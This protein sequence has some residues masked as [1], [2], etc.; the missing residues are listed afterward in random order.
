MAGALVITPVIVLWAINRAGSLRRQELLGA[1]S[2]ILAASAVGLIAFSPMVEPLLGRTPLGFL[3]ILPLTWAALRRGRRETATVAL[4]VSLLAIWGTVSGGGP[5]EP[6]TQ[7][8]DSFLLL[9]MFMIST[10]VPSLVL[11]ADVELRKRT[12]EALRQAHEKMNEIIHERTV[13]L[14]HT[15]QEL[16]QAQKIDALGQ[17]TSGIAHDFNNLLTAILG[18]LEL[19]MKYVT[20]ARAVRLVT[21]AREAAQH[22]ANLTAQLLSFSRKR[23]VALKPVNVNELIRGTQ[24]MLQRMV[25]P[26]V[27]ISYDL[28]NDAWPAMAN[29]DQLQ[30]SLLNLV[31]NAR[32]AMPLGGELLVSTRRRAG[33]RPDS[34]IP[35]VQAGDYLDISVSDTGSGMA[36]EIRS[37]AFEPFFTTKGPGKGSGLSLPMVYGF[38]RQAGGT[39]TIA[40]TPGKGTTVSIFL[41][42]TEAELPVTEQEDGRAPIPVETM[43]VL[44]VDDDES[45][46]ALTREMLEEMGHQVT[47]AGSGRAALEILDGDAEFDLLLVDFAMPGMNGSQLAAAALKLKPDL[48]ILFIT[49]YVENEVLRR[50]SSIGYRTLNKPF[51]SADLHTATREAVETFSQRRTIRIPDE[52]GLAGS[53][54]P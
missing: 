2:A 47:D 41:P 30:A 8:N 40:S 1:G 27:P 24:D 42:R 25:G 33:V 22:G 49:G 39:V 21:A 29:A 48:P 13:E 26:L 46:R 7:R 35:D 16:L 3:A 4:I 36:E 32:D 20:D 19:A 28:D 31:A 51:Q 53:E 18:S 38:A 44:L 23:D 34:R 17:L 6:P 10:A 11:S 14:E 9:I 52:L 45:V 12:E 37:K 5:F 15:R 43:R 50:W 54:R